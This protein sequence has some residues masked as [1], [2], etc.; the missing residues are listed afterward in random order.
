[1][2]KPVIISVASSKGGCGKSTITTFIS[3]ALASG[4]NKKVLILDTDNQK[5]I[6]D[7]ADSSDDTLVAVESMEPQRVPNFINRWGGDYDY[8]FIDIP[9]ITKKKETLVL[10]LL[11]ACSIILV[12]VVG[13]KVDFL[14]TLDFID[15]LE[16]VVSDRKK[17]G[18]KTAYF[19]F[20]NKHNRRKEIS[21]ILEALKDTSLKMFDNHLSDLK[22]FSSPELEVS[23]MKVKKD[24]FEPF[25]NEF[26]KRFKIK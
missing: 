23:M 20:I 16:G 2:K 15:I 25:Y 13:S 18:L 5:S 6:T 17:D 4:K 7:I 19:G 12:P 8:I 10:T 9:R 11:N 24:R 22:A 26:L 3:C 14:A 21:E 1:M